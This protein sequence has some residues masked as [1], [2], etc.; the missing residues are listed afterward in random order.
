M[1]PPK[2]R[3]TDHMIQNPRIQAS[4]MREV[5]LVGAGATHKAF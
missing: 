4:D 3:D 1:E 5:A 2:G